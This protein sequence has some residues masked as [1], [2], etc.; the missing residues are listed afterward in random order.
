MIKPDLRARAIQEHLYEIA[1]QD[2]PLHDGE[3][4]FATAAAPK[5]AAA[6]GTKP[7]QKPNAEASDPPDP[8]A[9]QPAE[10]PD[11]DAKEYPLPK[12]TPEVAHDEKGREVYVAFA[13][14]WFLGCRGTGEVVALPQPSPGC[15]WALEIRQIK[16]VNRAFLVQVELSTGKSAGDVPVHE[17]LNLQLY[18]LQQV[19]CFFFFVDCQET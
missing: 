12:G 5:A 8:D 2:A 10:E 15:T 17:H 16:G 13:A 6:P 4:P 9:T 7:P 1:F 18:R 3:E 14:K 19:L 11:D